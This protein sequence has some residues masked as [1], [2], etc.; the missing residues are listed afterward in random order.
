MLYKY[1]LLCFLPGPEAEI[2]GPVCCDH[3][4][5]GTWQLT[6]PPALAYS[7]SLLVQWPQWLAAVLCPVNPKQGFN[8]DISIP[9]NEE[10]SWARMALA[11]SPLSSHVG[12]DTLRVS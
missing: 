9:S 3:F 12:A 6:R 11:F 5:N 10:D 8:P 4:P 2:C 7:S 1:V